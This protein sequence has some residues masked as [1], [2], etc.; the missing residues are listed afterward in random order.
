MNWHQLNWFDYAI[1]IIIILSSVISLIRG[2]VRET[3]SLAAWIIAF[4]IALTFASNFSELLQPYITTQVIRYGAAF[5][6]L[7]VITL[8][9]GGFINY[10]IAQLVVKT[11]L[12]GSD[13]LLGIVFGFGR[14]I[15]LVAVILLVS[16]VSSLP[17]GELW[18]HSQLIPVFQPVEIWLSKYLPKDLDKK[19][20]RTTLLATP[21]MKQQEGKM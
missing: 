10:L 19:L 7:F 5:L 4:W 8:I 18:R 21:M 16:R 2:F 13:R 1:I 9:L 15:L 6:G 17:Q 12:S 3:L 11:G 14:G 20:S